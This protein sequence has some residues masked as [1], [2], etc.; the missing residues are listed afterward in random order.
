MAAAITRLVTRVSPGC[1]NRWSSQ[2]AG[3]T[4]RWRSEEARSRGAITRYTT[5]MASMK[6]TLI[7]HG[8]PTRYASPG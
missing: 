8:N 6:P 1:P 5:T 4:K 2:S 7:T 3:V